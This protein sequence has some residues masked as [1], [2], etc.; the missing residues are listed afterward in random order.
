ML[1]NN[2]RNMERKSLDDYRKLLRIKA[3]T[4]LPPNLNGLSLI[5]AESF[6]YYVKV[7]NAGLAFIV[8]DNAIFPVIFNHSNKS[9]I[10]YYNKEIAFIGFEEETVRDLFKD[11]IGK[12]KLMSENQD[13]FYQVLPVLMFKLQDKKLIIFDWLDSFK[14]GKLFNESNSLIDSKKEFNDRVINMF[15]KKQQKDLAKP[16][17]ELSEKQL[18]KAILSNNKLVRKQLKL[19][20]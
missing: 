18:A 19:R 9:D 20:K 11:I 14:K 7:K 16:I 15:V 17:N 10:V 1:G 2:S 6:P 13:D 3:E 4:F 12:S 5:V 8:K